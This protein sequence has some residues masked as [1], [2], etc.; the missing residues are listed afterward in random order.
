MPSFMDRYWDAYDVPRHIHH[1][2]PKSI[3]HLLSRIGFNLTET[4]PMRFDGPYV[5]IRSERH[6]N[7]PFSFIRGVFRGL[8][9]NLLAT[10]TGNY[11]SLTY[12][13][14]KPY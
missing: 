5:S 8:V 12:V 9:S 7:K 13:Y 1:F 11:S 10:R 6:S 4:I 2:S 14:Q 3:N